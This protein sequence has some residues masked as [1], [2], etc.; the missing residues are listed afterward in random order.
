MLKASDLQ[1][2]IRPTREEME[3]PMLGSGPSN[4]ELGA[5]CANLYVVVIA[6]VVY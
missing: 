4:V 1:R 5:H 6:V 3:S 2:D